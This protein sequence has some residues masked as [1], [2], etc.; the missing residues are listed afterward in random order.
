[1]SSQN[2]FQQSDYEAI[3]HVI[4][5]YAQ[6]WKWQPE[7]FREAFEEDAWIF[8]TDPAGGLQKYLLTDCFNEWAA[9][10]G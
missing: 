6:G 10:I 8:F 4:E 1:M 2:N 7:K 5:L 3:M 9:T